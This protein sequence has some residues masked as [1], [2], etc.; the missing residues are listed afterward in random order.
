MSST[1]SW[2]DHDPKERDRMNQILA[3]FKESGTRDEFGIGPIRDSFADLLF[4][5]TSTIQTRL[6]YMLFVPWIHKSLEEKNVP[7]SEIPRRAR[8]LVISLIVET[9]G[10]YLRV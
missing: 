3:L 9:L 2:I 4:P 10:S 6:R 8:N 5:G 1:L 7:S